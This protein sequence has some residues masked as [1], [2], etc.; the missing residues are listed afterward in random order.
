ML[1]TPE[2]KINIDFKQDQKESFRIHLN[3]LKKVQ[4]ICQVPQ[5]TNTF[6]TETETSN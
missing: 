3:K 2:A 6:K 5:Q 1:Q 4:I